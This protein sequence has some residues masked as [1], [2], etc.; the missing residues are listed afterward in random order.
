VLDRQYELTV[1]T[2]F[3]RRI[4][5][6]HR[7]RKCGS[8]VPSDAKNCRNC[9]ASNPNYA[10][11]APAGLAPAAPTATETQ[12]VAAPKQTESRSY[13]SKFCSGCGN[14]IHASARTCPQCG[15]AQ[16]GAGAA[17]GRDKNIAAVI[18]VFLGTF[19]AH[20]FYLG[21]N[22]LGI[23]Y[24]FFCWTTI[25]TLLGFIEGLIY[26]VSSDENFNKRYNK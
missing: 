19:G 20:H 14:T 1:S 25:P 8:G 3:S 2:I 21:N 9:G 12:S 6:M 16:A 11:A 22:L 23:L 24:L 13:N 10:P 17:G 4:Y 18:A 5:T 15:K 26:L 7:C